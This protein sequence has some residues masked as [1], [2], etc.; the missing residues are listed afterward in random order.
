MYIC[1]FGTLIF[2][3]KS[4]NS[5]VSVSDSYLLNT[6]QQA[7]MFVTAALAQLAVPESA[8]S[9]LLGS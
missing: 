2:A 9:C 6:Q 5:I 8:C 1:Q 7:T 4:M 3:I